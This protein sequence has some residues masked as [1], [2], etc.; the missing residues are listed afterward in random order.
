MVDLKAIKEWFNDE[1]NG[2]YWTS[3]DYNHCL[4][5]VLAPH[6]KALFKRATNKGGFVTFGDDGMHACMNPTPQNV[7]KFFKKHFNLDWEEH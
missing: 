1:N 2:M 7:S 3:S 5:D 6:E 4:C